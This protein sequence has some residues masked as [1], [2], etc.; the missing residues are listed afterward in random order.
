[1]AV[2]DDGSGAGGVASCAL[3]GIRKLARRLTATRDGRSRFGM[4]DKKF[5][6]KRKGSGAGDGG[7]A[8]NT[9]G[10]TKV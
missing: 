4:A 10:G 5:W 9:P 2:G 3:A 8:K 1:M 7:L 6:R